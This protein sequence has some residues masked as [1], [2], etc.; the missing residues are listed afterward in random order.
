MEERCLRGV[1]SERG[2]FNLCFYTTQ[3]HLSRGSATHSGLG[4]TI[5]IT[6]E[7]KA[8]ADVSHDNLMEVTP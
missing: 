3:G 1:Y 7:E 4:S 8:P 2:L 5:A 6:N